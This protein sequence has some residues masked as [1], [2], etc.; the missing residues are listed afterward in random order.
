MNALSA[1]SFMDPRPLGNDWRSYVGSSSFGVL[2]RASRM[3]CLQRGDMRRILGVSVRSIDD[4]FLRMT[5]SETQ[6]SALASTFPTSDFISQKFWNI[7]HWWPYGG[8]IPWNS[9]PWNL[10]I[11]PACARSCYHTLLFQMPGISHCPIH[12]MKLTE[13]CPRCDRS[14]LAGFRQGNP[15][16]ACP[17]GHDLVDFVATTEGESASVPQKL[18]M[19]C[20]YLIWAAASRRVNWLMAPDQWDASAWEAL[21]RLNTVPPVALIPAQHPIHGPS[22]KAA[23]VETIKLQDSLQYGDALKTNSG[24]DTFKQS[25]ASLPVSWLPALEGVS[26]ELAGMLPQEAVARIPTDR[27]FRNAIGRLPA[28]A[29]GSVIYLHTKC[30]HRVPLRV[31]GRLSTALFP[32]TPSRYPD[33][34]ALVQAVHQHA[35]GK[36]LLHQTVRRVLIRGYADGAR[37]VLGHHVPALYGHARTR[38]KTRFPW[39]VL[40]VPPGRMPTARIA[41][42]LQPGTD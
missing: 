35:F 39:V 17:C 19:V 12:N 1:S 24:L 2:W 26:H 28:H 32:K 9:M 16:G 13:T 37:V 4:V 34:D 41:W 27:D 5:R 20:G 11:C 23:F 14:L 25:V 6:R 18:D 15:L 3:N 36:H 7:E 10:R 21:H 30:L 8:V 33:D 22:G 38:P 40:S 31:L 29:C 42:T